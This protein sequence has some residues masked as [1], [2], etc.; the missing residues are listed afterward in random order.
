MS[1][2]PPVSYVPPS[3]E[4]VRYVETEYMIQIDGFIQVSLVSVPERLTLF[5]KVDDDLVK[6]MNVR[7]K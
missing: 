1:N 2:P 6:T 4:M 5:A 7:Y 3:D